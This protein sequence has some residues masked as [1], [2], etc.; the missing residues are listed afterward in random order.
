[1]TKILTDKQK[2]NIIKDYKTNQFTLA[3]LGLKYHVTGGT[4]AYT[5]KQN[6]IKIVRKKQ[7]TGR[8]RKYP[9]NDDYF[10]K[11]DTEDKAYFL[12]LLYADGCNYSKRNLITISL[13]DRDIDILQKFN[14]YLKHNK[15][16]RFVAKRTKNHVNQYRLDL[17]SKTMCESLISLGCIPNK[18]LILKFPTYHQ[19]P[20]HL[21]HHFL[22]GMWDGDGCISIHMKK[23]KYLDISACLA[24]CIPFCKSLKIYIKENLNIHCG[25]RLNK[26]KTSVQCT[27]SG[28]QQ[29]KRFL[30]WLYKNATVY[31]DRKYNKY[32]TV[33]SLVK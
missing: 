9:L 28:N 21:F 24:G 11:I 3:K 17:V 15:P 25:Y 18:T 32:L 30:R 29:T 31:L 10:N 7:G 6:K 5:L 22:R 33:I 16:L 8:K 14:K 23:Q 1:M 13:Q 27:V 19:V 12:G 20:K 26:R 2:K 4:I